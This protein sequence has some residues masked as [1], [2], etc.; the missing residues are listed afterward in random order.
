MARPLLPTRPPAESADPDDLLHLARTSFTDALTRLRES[1]SVATLRD[2]LP[3]LWQQITDP[4]SSLRTPVGEADVTTFSK[5]RLRDALDQIGSAFTLERARYY[6]DRL[7]RAVQETRT[8]RINDIDLNRWKE[9][10]D[11]LTDSLWLFDRRDASGAHHAGFWGNFVPQIPYQLMRRYT[12]RGDL[13]IDPFAGSGTTLIEGRRLGRHTIGVELNP[14]VVEQTRAT[15]MH[16]PDRHGVVCALEVG[17]S[18]TLDWTALL[19][20]Y[21]R[22]S[23]QLVILHPPYHDIIRFS[24]DPRDLANAPSVETFLAMLGDVVARV[25]PVLDRGRYLALVLGDKYA[26]GEWIPLGFLGM[27][28]T[29]RHGFTLKS[30]VVKNFEQTAGKRSQKE[31]WR[32]RALVGGFYVFKHEYIFL[33]RKA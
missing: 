33:F 30:I 11:I 17:D 23:A 26:D 8:G 32:Y 14:A 31:L 12:R 25:A 13:V 4:S 22:R 21:G 9:Y 18:T 6:L 2:A 28:E 24:D 1:E 5:R 7:A 29:L 10:D 3:M 27:Q 20:Q 19:E 15:L 16:E